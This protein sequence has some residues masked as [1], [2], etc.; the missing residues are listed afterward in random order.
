MNPVVRGALVLGGGVVVWTFVMG[1]TG[2]YRH[3]TLLHLFLAV[4]IPWQV[5]V[6]LWTLR[7]SA[8]THGYLRQVASGLATSALGGV[9]I[10][11]GSLAFTTLAFPD[12]FRELEATGRALMVQKGVAPDQIEAAIRAAA[13]TQTPMFNALSGAVGTLVTGLLVSLVAAAFIRRR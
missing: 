8:P 12:Y 13:P 11:L 2:W 5:A 10:F 1:F 4:A 6:L 7:A 3:P 9:L